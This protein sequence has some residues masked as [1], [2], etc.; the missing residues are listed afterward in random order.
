MAPVAS[1]AENS[2]VFP[3]GSVAVAV[4]TRPAGNPAGNVT[5][6]VASPLAFVVTGVVLKNCAPSPL[7]EGSTAAFVK[8]SIWKVVFGIDFKLPWIVVLLLVDD[9]DVNTGKF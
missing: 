6:I 3:L 7:P 1:A 5:L 2:D 4:M 9:S 8:K